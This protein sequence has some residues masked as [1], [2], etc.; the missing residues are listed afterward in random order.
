MHWRAGYCHLEHYKH[1]KYFFIFISYLHIS[2]LG[3]E[4]GELVPFHGSG[5]EWLGEQPGIIRERLKMTPPVDIT[6]NY[7][8]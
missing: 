8:Y 7:Y 2:C 1:L 5:A 3:I 6:S 4:F